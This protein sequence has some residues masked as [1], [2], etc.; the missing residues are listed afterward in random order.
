VIYTTPFGFIAEKD[1]KTAHGETVK[2]SIA[3]L[4]FKFIAE[5]LKKEP[6]LADTII[7][8]QYYRVVTGACEQGI[9]RWKGFNKIDKKEIRA[10]ELLPLLE[11]T[12]AYGLDIFKQMIEWDLNE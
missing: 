5:K 11:K 2:K 9:I 7:T 10:D 12:N 4:E 6:I 8:D 3:D 1:D